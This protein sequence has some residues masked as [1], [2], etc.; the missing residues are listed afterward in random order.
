MVKLRVEAEYERAGADSGG[1]VVVDRAFAG[2]D[3]RGEVSQD[4]EEPEVVCP[5]VEVHEW[6]AGLSGGP[7]AVGVGGGAEDVD[8]RAGLANVSARGAPSTR[9][10][11]G[12][13]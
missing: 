11:G 5:V 7:G 2:E 10:S 8:V 4:G 9:L 6:V 13:A 1:G 12:R 3:R